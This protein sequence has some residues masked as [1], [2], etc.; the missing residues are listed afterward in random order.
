MVS[1]Y[2]AVAERNNPF[3]QKELAGYLAIG[4]ALGDQAGYL[5]L[6]W[7]EQAWT[8]RQIRQARRRR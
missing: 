1:T 8:E 3:R 5:T 2:L 4:Q 6:T 7:R